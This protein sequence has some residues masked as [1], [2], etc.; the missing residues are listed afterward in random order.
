VWSYICSNQGHFWDLCS[1]MCSKFDSI[2]SP[3]VNGK[4]AA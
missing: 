1:G 3:E 2:S 4:N